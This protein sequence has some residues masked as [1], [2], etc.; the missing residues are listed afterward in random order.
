MLIDWNKKTNN[1]DDKY[2]N[3]TN[4]RAKASLNE[5]ENFLSQHVSQLDAVSEVDSQNGAAPVD[6][7]REVRRFAQT[8]LPFNKDMP[9]TPRENTDPSQQLEPT[10][11]KISSGLTV[12]QTK[13]AAMNNQFSPLQMNQMRNSTNGHVMDFQ[14]GEDPNKSFGALRKQD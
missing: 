6:M 14:S 3:K 13:T 12:K 9:L 4:Y 7:N 8:Q 2:K 11:N 5:A 10:M 1:V